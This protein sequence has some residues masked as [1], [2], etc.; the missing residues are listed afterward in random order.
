MK[1]SEFQDEVNKTDQQQKSEQ[2]K[3]NLT[4]AIN[5]AGIKN[6]EATNA[7][8][9]STSKALKDVRGKVEVTN[10]DLAKSGDLNKVVDSIN[11]MNV[12][13]FMGTTGFHDMAEN[14]SRLSEE[15][16]TLQDKLKNEG[17]T[18]I[19]DSFSGL[20]GK[21]ADISKQMSS[22]KLGVDNSFVKTVA[23]L[24]KSID[25]IDFKPTVNVQAPDTKVVQTPVDMDSVIKALGKVQ[26]AIS[27]Q[28]TPPEVDFSP[29]T[30][31][32]Q[33]VQDAITNLTFPV[34]N[35]VLPFKDI[36]G[37]ATQVQLD[38]SGNVPTSGGGSGGG[39]TQYQELATTTPA[40]GTLALARYKSSAPTL[41]DGQM[42][43]PLLDASGN[44]KVNVAAGGASGGTSSSY[45]SA[46]PATGTA[47]GATDGTNMQSL[48]VD[49]SKN[50]LTAV[51][52]ALPAGSNAI[53]SITNTSFGANQGTAAAI[54]A[55]WPVIGGELADTTGTF[56]NATQTTSVTTSSFDGYS[57]IIV[58][59]NGTYGTATGVFEISDD[60]GTT[61]YSVNAARTDGSAV[62]VGYTALT[63]TN[64]MWTL[65]VS[66]ADEFRVRSTAVASGTVN[67]RISVESMPTPEA[68]SITAY[69]PTAGNFN[70][71]VVGTG[72]FA[73]QPTIQTGT[74]SIGKISDITTSVVPGVAA[75]NL[76]KA[77][78]AVHASGDTGVFALTVANEA[79]TNISGTDGDYTIIG[80]DRNGTIH[81]AQKAS[82]ATLSNVAGSATSVTLLSANAA[83]IGAQITNDSSAVVYIKFGTTASTTSYT[84][85]LAGAA[86]APFS[87]YEVPAGYTGRIDAIWAS[88]TGNARITE[89]TP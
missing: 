58:S 53:G 26:D 40:T 66:G 60:A 18:N 38:S 12:T 73:T 3:A 48:K 7:N 27:K 33:S 81:V 37:K 85:V 77:E 1:P 21:L 45:G 79:L 13:T 24:K 41:T 2:D 20:V 52:V 14:I 17:L 78:D 31:G 80:S 6:V 19:S 36:N 76:G 15:V 88:A 23:D 71:T 87:Y 10:P 43:E 5:K 68:A 4:G 54:T 8:A 42:F 56:T 11:K 30:S 32:L 16:N 59:I 44:L 50:L 25:S 63:N 29:V 55:G 65:S 57:T 34:A 22:T 51:N 89:I 67:V 70:A 46:F 84:V 74:N 86:S 47:I 39:G 62:E 9:Q 64:R 28:E 69:Q 75:T 61:W 49:G 72:T 35:Y 82:T 83:R